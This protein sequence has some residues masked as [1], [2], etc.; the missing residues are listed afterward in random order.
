MPSSAP[1][2]GRVPWPAAS[3][4]SPPTTTG[5]PRRGSARPSSGAGSSPGTPTVGERFARLA[6]RFVWDRPFTDA[7]IR[8]IRRTKARVEG[9]RL[10]ADEDPQFHLKLGRGSL[11]DIEWTAQLLQLTHGCGPP[12]TLQAL[13]ALVVPAP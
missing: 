11:A 13:D 2:A 9:E 8:E 1:R 7:D 12:G 4:P 3:T 6:D 5:G 10:P